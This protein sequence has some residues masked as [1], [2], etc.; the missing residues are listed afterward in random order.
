M[1]WGDLQMKTMWKRILIAIWLG[2]L[3]PWTILQL[4]V[5]REPVDNR[6]EDT[7]GETYS[8]AAMIGVLNGAGEPVEMDMKTYVT[9]VVLAEMPAEFEP[10]ALKAQAV[11]ARTYARKRQLMGDKHENGYICTNAACCQAFMSPEDYLAA[12]G[13][14]EHLEKVSQAVA[15]TDPLVLTYEGQLIDATF[16]A[17]SG[18]STEDAAAVW[19]AEVPYLQAV[20]SPGEEIAERF[21]E[22]I[23]L[24]RGE[25]A[26]KLSLELDQLTGNFIGAVTYTRGGGVDQIQL[27]GVT[28]TGL[29]VRQ[30]LSL[31]STAFYMTAIGDTVTITTRGHGHRVGMSQYGAEAMAV[32]G[33]NFQQILSHYYPGTVLEE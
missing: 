22:T 12:G 19:G 3:L 28:Y 5:K 26:Q 33:S 6:P 17:C 32:D 27:A 14:L 18:G 4:L 9:G 13:S 30:L 20:E 11:V 29:A 24:S 25:F 16:F 7:T 21:T 1:V 31:N 8:A 10:E 23:K 15:V 2:L